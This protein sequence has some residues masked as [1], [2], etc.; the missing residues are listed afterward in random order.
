MDSLRLGR[1]RWLLVGYVA[2]AV[3]VVAAELADIVAIEL[4]RDPLELGG[5]ADTHPWKGS[6]SVLG[7]ICWSA[8]AAVCLLAGALVRASGAARERGKFLLATGALFLVLGL[9]DGLLIHDHWAERIT[10]W[11]VSQPITSAFLFLLIGLW[12]VVFRRQ[13]LTTNVLLLGLALSGLFVAEVIDMAGEVDI[14]SDAANLT[15]EALEF[16]AVVTFLVYAV[17]EAWSA[18]RGLPAAPDAGIS[19]MEAAGR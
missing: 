6:F 10:H 14:R 17:G 9:D 7:V 4:F 2:I 13:I 15:E 5:P 3:F 8:A 12:L 1:L 11:E 16:G 19:T 18:L